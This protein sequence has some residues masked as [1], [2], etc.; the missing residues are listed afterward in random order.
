M[1]AYEFLGDAVNDYSGRYHQGYIASAI[2]KQDDPDLYTA[3]EQW[4]DRPELP[5]PEHPIYPALPQVA[6]RTD[7]EPPSVSS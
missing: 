6:A 5:A 7:P 2:L 3:I 1:A 4:V